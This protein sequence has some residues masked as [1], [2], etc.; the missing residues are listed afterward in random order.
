[1]GLVDKIVYADDDT[2]KV[3]L[4]LRLRLPWL[5]VGLVGGTAASFLVSR[6]EPILTQNISLAFFLPL[7]VYMSDAV[8]TQTEN[9]FV[10]N[11]GKG[12]ARFFTYLIK[13]FFIG[14]GLG[15]IFAVLIGLVTHFW[16]GSME[17]TTTVS[18]A[19]FLTVSVAP[20]IALIV[21]ELITKEHRDPALGSGPFTT[22]VQNIVSIIIYFLVASWV[23]FS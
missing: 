11:L 3:S 12:E 13:E 16:I 10:R 22:I 21:P 23:F 19:M 4:L 6:F 20:I 1:M 7:I 17:I 2:E 14:V 15:L 8:G 5:L 9:I 18:L